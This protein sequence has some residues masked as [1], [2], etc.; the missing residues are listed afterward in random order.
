MGNRLTCVNQKQM[1][2]HTHT[3]TYGQGVTCPRSHAHSRRCEDTHA[4]ARTTMQR[5]MFAYSR[6]ACCTR[7]AQQPTE[8]RGGCVNWARCPADGKG[9]G[10][11]HYG[12]TTMHSKDKKTWHAFSITVINNTTK[13]QEKLGVLYNPASRGFCTL[14]NRIVARVLCH[15]TQHLLWLAHP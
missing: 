14:A 15:T 4:Y 7:S 13:R 11:P 6:S 12:D 1:Y 2:T 8:R 10:L 9:L 5:R 3:S